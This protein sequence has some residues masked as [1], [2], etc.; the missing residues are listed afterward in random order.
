M[1]D[2]ILSTVFLGIRTISQWVVLRCVPCLV[3]LVPQDDGVPLIRVALR[4]ILC[5]PYPPSHR[6][7]PFRIPLQAALRPF[8]NSLFPSLS[9]L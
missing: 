1:V 4:E 6:H 7:C 2:F 5:C 3:L 8:S 9:C